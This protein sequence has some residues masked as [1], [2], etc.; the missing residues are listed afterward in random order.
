MSIGIVSAHASIA[1]GGSPSAYYSAVAAD[2]PWGFWKTDETSGTSLV[3]SSGNSRPLATFNSPTLAQTGPDGSYADAISWTTAASQYAQS[4]GFTTNAGAFTHEAWVY[5]SANPATRTSI[6]GRALAYGDSGAA[7]GALYINT[8]GT[9]GFYCYNG[10]GQTITTAGAL[11]QNT[12]HHIVGSVGAAGTKIRID[13]S[14]VASNAGVTTGYTGANQ[15][16][17]L[18]G[19]QLN[20]NGLGAMKIARPAYYTSQLSDARTDAHYDAL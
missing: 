11:S 10:A 9:V 6:L 1:G 2:S 14:T 4:T 8:D 19:A 17:F 5:Y 13:K 20:Y 15:L 16:I 18:R 12:W 3:D 7:D